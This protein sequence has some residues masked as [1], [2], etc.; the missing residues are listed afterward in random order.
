MKSKLTLVKV[1]SCIT[2][3]SIKQTTDDVTPTG[4]YV[5]GWHII[6]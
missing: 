1:T 6:K 3:K 5:I 4:Y 2:I